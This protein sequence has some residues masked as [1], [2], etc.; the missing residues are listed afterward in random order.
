MGSALDDLLGVSLLLSL[1]VGRGFAEPQG[2]TVMLGALVLEG[3]PQLL[4]VPIKL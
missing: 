1:E 3:Q 2:R 4:V